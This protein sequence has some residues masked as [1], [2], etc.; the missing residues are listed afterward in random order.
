MNTD[1]FFENHQFMEVES[2]YRRF[3]KIFKAPIFFS[4]VIFFSMI[5]INSTLDIAASVR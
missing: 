2:F 4:E 5:R 1:Q 3:G